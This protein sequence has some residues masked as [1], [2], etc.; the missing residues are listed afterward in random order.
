ML[1]TRSQSVCLGHQPEESFVLLTL[2]G[3]RLGATPRVDAPAEAAP[4][5]YAQTLV[6]DLCA[7]ENATGIIPRT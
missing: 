5:D 2:N 4:A 3:K 6:T 7:D 1:S